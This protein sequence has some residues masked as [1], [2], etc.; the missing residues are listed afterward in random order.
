[1]SAPLTSTTR[2]AEET[3][4]LGRRLG[5]LAQV[6]DLFLL[7]GTLGSG[8][9]TLTQ[10]VA[11]GAGVSGYAH[12]PTFVIVHE[13]EGRIPIYHVDLYRI[14]DTL[15]VEELALDELLERGVC[16]VEWP[17]RAP[18]AFPAERLMVSIEF[19]DGPDTRVITL[20]PVGERYERIT[21]SLR[22]A[23]PIGTGTD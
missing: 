7:H 23:A 3:Q 13:Y 18:D 4:Q 16:V 19:G 5:A 9:T 6:G 21:A 1:M 11:W 12:S 2:S 8:K 20:T 17:E 15:E 22:S 14:E 10:G